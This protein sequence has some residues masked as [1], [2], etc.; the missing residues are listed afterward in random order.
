MIEFTSKSEIQTLNLAQ[1]LG[2]HAF[3][4]AVV[5]LTGNLGAGKTVFAKGLA[6]GLGFDG[7]VKSPTYNIMNIYQ[8]TLPL[9]HFDLYRLNGVDDFHGIGGEEYIGSQNVCAIEWHEHAQGAFG[10]EYLE[11]EIGDIEENER[12]INLI[13]KGIKHEEWLDSIHDINN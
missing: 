1:Q 12:T 9:I 11:V 10:D 3:P 2:K 7:L 6:Q 8:G 13:A 4:G 5:L